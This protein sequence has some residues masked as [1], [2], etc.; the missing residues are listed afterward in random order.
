MNILQGMSDQNRLTSQIKKE[1]N[2]NNNNI[3]SKYIYLKVTSS[4]AYGSHI[5]AQNSM[6]CLKM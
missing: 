5:D 4:I 2:K 1:T 6:F 3:Y